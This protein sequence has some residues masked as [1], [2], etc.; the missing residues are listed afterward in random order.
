[1]GDGGYYADG[2]IRT[3]TVRELAVAMIESLADEKATA[4]LLEMIEHPNGPEG[5]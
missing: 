2:E 1:M 5:Q 3:K 4:K